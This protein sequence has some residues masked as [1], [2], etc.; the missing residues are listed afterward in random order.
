MLDGLRE[1]TLFSRLLPWIV[2]AVILLLAFLFVRDAHGQR[3]TGSAYAEVEAW[4]QPDRCYQNALDGGG[5]AT[6][7]W[8]PVTAEVGMS[9]KWWGACDAKAKG[10]FFN[11]EAAK[12]IGRSRHATVFYHYEGWAAG[13][14]VRRNGVH[15]VWRNQRDRYSGF[16]ISNDWRVANRRCA[17][18]TNP[19]N[20]E[21]ACPTIGYWDRLGPTVQYGGAW[22][23]VQATYLTYQWKENTLTPTEWL[24]HA[25]VTPLDRWRVEADVERDLSGAWQYDLHAERKMAR[26]IWLGVTYGKIGDPGWRGGFRRVAAT[27]SVR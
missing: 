8:G 27:V 1:G 5:S 24:F 4:A 14:T 3:L 2:V 25:T 6:A 11:A 16:P 10:S 9:L 19:P 21:A 17:T 7:T 22:G 13:I 12:V 26:R 20:R 18:G 15:H 23:E